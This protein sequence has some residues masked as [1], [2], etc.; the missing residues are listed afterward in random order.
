MYKSQRQQIA[1]KCVNHE[2]RVRIGYRVSGRVPVRHCSWNHIFPVSPVPLKNYPHPAPHIHTPLEMST[3]PGLR[4]TGGPKLR[5]AL[6]PILTSF[7]GRLQCWGTAQVVRAQKGF[8]T[9]SA[10]RSPSTMTQTHVARYQT[11]KRTLM[12]YIAELRTCSK[13]LENTR[14]SEKTYNIQCK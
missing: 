6:Q 13:S 11:L 9:D 8:E 14:C 7:S 1:T 4:W 3:M 10:E 12:S 2:N 5:P